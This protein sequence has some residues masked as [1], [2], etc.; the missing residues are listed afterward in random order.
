MKYGKV[1]LVFLVLL[2]SSNL[3]FSN[4]A[5]EYS[6]AMQSLGER[7][8]V[9]FTF[10]VNS[11]LEISKLTTVISIDKVTNAT[12]VFAYANRDEFHEFLKY[13]YYYEV[14]PPPSFSEPPKMSDFSKRP[15]EWDSYPTLQGY[16]DMMDKFAS[17]YPDLCRIE[18]YGTSV[19][20]KKLLAAK[21]SDNVN[22]EEK[23]PRFFY[24]STIH[25]DE[26]CG[27]V[28]MLRL[29]DTLLTG[30]GRDERVTRLV[31]SVEIWINPD[32]NP[33][34]TYRTT[35]TSTSSAVRNNADGADLNR[36]FP[37]PTGANTIQRKETY[38]IM[39]FC[40]KYPFTLSCDHHGGFELIAYVWGCWSNSSHPHADRNW[41]KMVCKEYADTAQEYSPAGY[42]NGT[43][44]TGYT[45]AYE[46]YDVRGERM[47]YANHTQ[48]CKDVTV[49]ISNTKKLPAS[50]LPA[51][52]EY[53][54]RSLFRYIEH[55]LYGIKGTVTDSI[56]GEPLKAKVFVE[57]HDK[58]GSWTFSDSLH[59]GYFRPIYEGKYDVTFS[60]DNYQTKTIEDVEVENYEATILDVELFNG[61]SIG[62]P[63]Q[64][65]SKSDILVIPLNKG[66]KI[67]CK[68][69]GKIVR[70]G[71]YDLNG[72]LIQQLPIQKTMV[73]NGKNSR[74]NTISNGYYIVKI[75]TDKRTLTKN[76]V[77]S[78]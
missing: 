2:G 12:E 20:G 34:G 50:E 47:N 22:E 52:W 43:D 25:G 49:E 59:G 26:L 29:I 65:K 16:Y 44:G 11:P 68:E 33:D 17:D 46:W 67:S 32:A 39:D 74:G 69:V 18:E 40:D 9:C 37:C 75:D 4:N 3:L 64:I 78:R 21:I 51:Y 60:C 73:W 70:V 71:I 54:Y 45:S 31:D 57:A 42:F 48:H 63:S 35:E 41:W 6:K 38:A 30:Y 5:A 55:C 36:S 72:S 14:E 7:G 27:Y 66:I 61:I 10:Y 19:R 1:A 13:N 62:N 58:D 56:S 24:Q 53:Q 77:L 76:F 28:L 15:Y 8:E 23:E